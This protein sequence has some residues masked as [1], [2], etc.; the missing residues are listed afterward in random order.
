MKF[1]GNW[2]RKAFTIFLV[3]FFVLVGGK[4][5]VINTRADEEQRTILQPDNVKGS[6]RFIDEW[7]AISTRAVVDSDVNNFF[8]LISLREEINLSKAIEGGRIVFSTKLGTDDKMGPSAAPVD[9]IINK[10]G[11]DFSLLMTEGKDELQSLGY[12]II[13]EKPEGSHFSDYKGQVLGVNA[14]G[15]SRKPGIVNFTTTLT[16]A[17]GGKMIMP[18]QV[19]ILPKFFITKD[20]KVVGNTSHPQLDFTFS[21]EPKDDA[22]DLNLDPIKVSYN[23][24][25]KGLKTT[26]D[27]IDK[28]EEKQPFTATG[29]Y[30][31]ILSEKES[32]YVQ[33]DESDYVDNLEKSKAKYEVTFTVE[34]NPKGGGY[35]V[36]S[37]AVKHL[38]A[39]NGTDAK[40][41]KIENYY[42]EGKDNDIRF[43]NEY[44]KEVKENEKKP[45]ENRG[46]YISKTVTGELGDKN[47][48]FPFNVELK[49]PEE[50]A[51]KKNSQGEPI[52]LNTRA[53]IFNSRVN[54]FEKDLQNNGI[55]A[56]GEGYFTVTYGKAFT[57]NLKHGQ[58]IVFEKVFVGS[59]LTANETDSKGHKL[60]YKFVSGGTEISGITSLNVSDK[61]INKIE[62][63]NQKNQISPQTGFNTNA[64]SFM[65]MAVV[66]SIGLFAMTF[67][68]LKKKEN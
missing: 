37:V 6:I 48:Y 67:I 59:T 19:K 26:A 30:T 18:M 21:F 31:Y 41:V 1:K 68:V 44:S 66:G 34:S 22:P 29:Q 7:P 53:R 13:G 60:T 42:Q 63:L 4:N 54:R 20:F 3:L 25:E 33:H 52:V 61:G 64:T 62:V 51:Q 28:I 15:I 16:Y 45:L 55:N 46:L 8:V 2:L 57:L 9:H 58:A 36:L 23:A 24:D 47:Q 17:E 14:S 32:S 43:T 11:T 50:L 27:I 56:D 65:L 10:G 39:D 35:R 12:E 38:N 5:E 40:G 49:A